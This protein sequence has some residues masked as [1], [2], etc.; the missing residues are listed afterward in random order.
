M[1]GVALRALGRGQLWGIPRQGSIG[2]RS[3]FCSLAAPS[4]KKRVRPWGNMGSS[5]RSPSTSNL[6][7][8]L[9]SQLVLGCSH[10]T[11]L[12]DFWGLVC[13]MR[14]FIEQLSHLLEGW[15]H[16]GLG[17]GDWHLLGLKERGSNAPLT[18]PY[19]LE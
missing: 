6:P 3:S 16:G 19:P 7:C 18:Y 2:A 8:Y 15:D 1:G 4:A 13:K 12:L 10:S 11:L 5:P 14:S 17:E 9:A